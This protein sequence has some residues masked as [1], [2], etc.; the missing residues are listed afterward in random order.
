MCISSMQEYFWL[1]IVQKL[2]LKISF[3]RALGFEQHSWILNKIFLK[4]EYSVLGV[5]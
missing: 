3:L 4:L 2:S 1:C 5:K